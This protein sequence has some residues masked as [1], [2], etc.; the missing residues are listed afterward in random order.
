MAN[1]PIVTEVTK[2]QLDALVAANGLN[3]GLQYKVTDKNWLLIATSNNT[4]TNIDNIYILVNDILPVWLRPQNLFIYTNTINYDISASTGTPLYIS[5]LANH[6]LMYHPE[7]LIF[8]TNSE[9]PIEQVSGPSMPVT[10]M[11]NKEKYKHFGLVIPIQNEGHRF[12]A[13]GIT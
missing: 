11:N 13:N 3:E 7:S 1:V 10:D 2:A 6:D 5:C 4:V 8:M 9:D 12:V